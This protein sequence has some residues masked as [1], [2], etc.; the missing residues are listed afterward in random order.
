MFRLRAR[1]AEIQNQWIT[2]L[3]QYLRHLRYNE[4]IHSSFLT[5]IT[6]E[7][8]SKIYAYV[9][10]GSM[11]ISRADIEVAS[12]DFPAPI[13]EPAPAP[14]AISFKAAAGM[15]S[16]RGAHCHLVAPRSH[17]RLVPSCGIGG[18]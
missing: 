7:R 8:N 4:M 18:W 12:Y 1:T 5:E 14:G 13:K 2:H 11:V 3:V 10:E 16:S 6:P 9:Q 15:T 17:A